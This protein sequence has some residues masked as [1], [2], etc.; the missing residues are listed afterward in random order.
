ML[1]A[2][3]LRGVVSHRFSNVSFRKLSRFRSFR[4]GNCSVFL[5]NLPDLSLRG[6]RKFCARRGNLERNNLSFR[7]EIR[8]DGTKQNPERK[9]KRN[10]AANLMFFVIGLP[11]CFPLPCFAAGCHTFGLKIATAA[12]RP[13][14]DTNLERFCFG[15]GRFCFMRPFCAV[16][17]RIVFQT[18]RFKNCS[19]FR[20]T[21]QICHCEEGANFAP[22]AA[23]LNGTICHS[24]TKYGWTERNRILKERGSETKQR[25]S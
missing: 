4:S 16:L 12:L 17:P 10:E 20:K 11:S 2:A 9:R 13:R 15:N 3:F 21:Y 19:I 5:Q 18:F 7:N 8:L 25:I 22:D 23:I 6:G 1:Y 24:G 14:N